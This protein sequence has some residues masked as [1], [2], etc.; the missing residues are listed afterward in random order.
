[1]NTKDRSGQTPTREGW[2][3]YPIN[4]GGTHHVDLHRDNAKGSQNSTERKPEQAPILR[5]TDA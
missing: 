2:I 3:K 5:T 4:Y 1:M